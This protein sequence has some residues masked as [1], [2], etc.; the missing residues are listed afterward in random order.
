MKDATELI[1]TNQ[2]DS[3]GLVIWITGLSG[4]GKTTLAKAIKEKFT[5][6][7]QGLILLDGDEMR[8]VFQNEN[9][10]VLNYSKEERKN[11]ALK[12]SKIC[13][14]LSRQ[15]FNVVIAT[16]SMLS[17]VY[18]WNRN[19]IENYFEIYLD[20][21]M[22]ELRTR[23]QKSIYSSFEKGEINNVMGLDLEVVIPIEPD[24]H[25]CWNKNVSTESLVQE[26]YETLIRQKRI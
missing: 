21:P 1:N 16:I 3:N 14:I 17:E 24:I 6:L 20:V 13:Q 12:Y 22:S 25:I 23:D 7:H 4:A 19:N 10:I 15:N 9:E 26:I 8:Q 5:E 18:E 11:L 2:Y